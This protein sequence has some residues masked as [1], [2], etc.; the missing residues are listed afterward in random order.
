MRD[1]ERFVRNPENE[2]LRS[3]PTGPVASA[4]DARRLSRL[5]ATRLVGFPDLEEAYT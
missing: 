2:D 4:P 1:D 5:S 3:I